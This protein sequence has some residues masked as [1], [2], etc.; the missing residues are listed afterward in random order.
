MITFK[1]IG[2][3]KNTERFLTK[4]QQL[5]VGKILSGYGAKGVQA[6]ANATPVRTGLTA[7]SW[8]Y[9]IEVTSWGYALSWENSNVNAGANVAILIQ[10]GHGTGTGGY[11]QGQD[12][13]NP[14][15][16]PLFD[17]MAE[18]IWKEVTSL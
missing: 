17:E 3:F 11:V 1:H 7:N 15:I 14:A 2:S 6:L 8:A 12:Y 9:S 10:Y 16:Q 5:Q 4:A 18:A 13:I